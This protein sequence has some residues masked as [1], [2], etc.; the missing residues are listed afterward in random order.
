MIEIVSVEQ[1][2]VD[3]LRELAVT[4]FRETFGHANTEKNLQAYFKNDLS[5]DTLQQELQNPESQYYF[6]KQYGDIAGFLKL[7]YGQAQTEQALENAMEVQRIYILKQYQGQK[8]GKQ[9]FEFALE[10][11]Y[12]SGCDWLWLGVWEHNDKAQRFYQK[13]GFEKFSE[14]QF[15]LGDNDD[16]DWLLKKPLTK[17]GKTC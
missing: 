16:T 14:H 2:Q 9:L 17:E 11:A 13:Y 15:L 1:N 5:R 4:T 10:K 12:A 3:C 8:L 7:N 6:M